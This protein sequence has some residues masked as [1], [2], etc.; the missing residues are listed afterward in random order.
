[1]FRVEKFLPPECPKCRHKFSKEGKDYNRLLGDII[2]GQKVV[3]ETTG[4]DII[5]CKHCKNATARVMLEAYRFTH[6]TDAEFF[7]QDK[8]FLNLQE[9]EAFGNQ[10]KDAHEVFTAM[11]GLHVCSMKIG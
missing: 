6:R 7:L 3:R 11:S 10:R 8:G 2:R 5:V 1:M 4:Y 9:V